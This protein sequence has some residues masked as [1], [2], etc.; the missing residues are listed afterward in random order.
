MENRCL[1]DKN[2]YPDDEVLTRYLGKA[3]NAWD[4]FMDLLK[5]EH[6]L[7]ST[8]WRYYNDGKS[9]LCKATQKGKTVCW[10][11]VWD[12]LFKVTFY[13][14][15]KAEEAIK[16]SSLDKEMKEQWM[17]DKNFGKIKPITLEVRKITDLITIKKLIELKE[18]IK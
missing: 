12:E 13:F 1:N 8:E 14:N 4:S 5:V 9:W 11:S 7:I 17:K 10:I 3:K 18:S 2:T 16:N 15:V 6:P